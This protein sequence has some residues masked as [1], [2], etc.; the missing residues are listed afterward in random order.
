MT[1]ND[2]ARMYE[3]SYA[4]LNRN[5]QDLDHEDT[6]L[7]P[8]AGGNCLNWVLGHVVS[9]RSMVLMLAGATPT[10]TGEGMSVYRRGSHPEGTSGFADLAKLR[11]MFDQ[12]QE[13]LI[14]ALTALS[15]QAL[16]GAVPEEHRRPPLTGTLGDALIRLHYHEG[17]H[18]GQ[19]GLLRRLAGK[20]EAIA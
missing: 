2:L 13:Q 8:D 5:L 15:E 17:Y 19:I 16:N 9:A 1:G 6:L 7:L 14:P 12:T 3:F 10:L 11:A 18:N 20:P 4:A